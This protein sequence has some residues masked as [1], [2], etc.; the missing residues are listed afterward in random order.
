M[1][2]WITIGVPVFVGALGSGVLVE[3]V[4]LAAARRPLRIKEEFDNRARWHEEAA[5]ER[6]RRR[7]AHHEAAA[8]H[9]DAVAEVYRLVN[10]IAADVIGPEVDFYNPE[11]LTVGSPREAA[12]E[13]ITLL[14]G[15]WTAHPTKTVRLA[16]QAL[17]GRLTEFYGDPNNIQDEP[18][19]WDRDELL[20]HIGL[21]EEVIEALHTTPHPLTDRPGR[22]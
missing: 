18:E 12:G 6:E 9:T 20:K 4:R 13:A 2:E 21:A 10:G 1:N 7:A 17:S 15:V 5:A 3:C 19:F 11:N 16:A 22:R 8:R 14:R